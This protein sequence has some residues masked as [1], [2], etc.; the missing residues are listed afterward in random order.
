MQAYARQVTPHTRVQGP[1]LVSQ[2]TAQ[3]SQT[4]AVAFGVDAGT[5][6]Y[7][8]PMLQNKL[9]L[10]DFVQG[11]AMQYISMQHHMRVLTGPLQGGAVAFADAGGS[12]GLV[13]LRSG[14]ITVLEGTSILHVLCCTMSCSCSMCLPCQDWLEHDIILVLGYQA[15]IVHGDSS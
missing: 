3:E 8:S 9:L 14:S 7:S 2:L 12:V 5:L 13:N 15:F 1:V 10:Y 4:A 11:A 6:V